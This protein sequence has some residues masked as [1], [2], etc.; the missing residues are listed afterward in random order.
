MKLRLNTTIRM[1]TKKMK[2][3]DADEEADERG[4]D[5]YGKRDARAVEHADE[6]VAADR[7]GAEPMRA[8]GVAKHVLARPPAGRAL[9]QGIVDLLIGIGRQQRREDRHQRDDGEEYHADQRRPVA[10]QTPARIHPQAAAFDD[11]R[12]VDEV[13]PG[14][15]YHR[16][17][18]YLTR[19]SSTR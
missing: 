16:H 4:D 19:G 7:I 18:S 12:G 9:H 13:G 6:K 11:A 10:E 15:G 17:H 1:M 3:S 14:A 8:A 2:G 5:A